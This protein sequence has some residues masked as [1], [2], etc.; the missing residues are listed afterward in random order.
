MDHIE[1]RGDSH[2]WE[3]QESPESPLGWAVKP[4]DA[5]WNAPDGTPMFT[6]LGDA[7]GIAKFVAGKLRLLARRL[8]SSFPEETIIDAPRLYEGSPQR[9]TGTCPCAEIEAA[10]AERPFRWRDAAGANYPDGYTERCFWCSCG[11]AWWCADA[12]EQAWVQVSSWPAFCML[13]R[14]SGE[15]GEPVGVHPDRGGLT[16]LSEIC[17]S[18]WIPVG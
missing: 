15:P 7:D 10:T 12:E 14:H 16:L 9:D 18:G 13:V 11:K 17:S 6:L 8:Q 2:K 3:A 5:H 1:R 4:V